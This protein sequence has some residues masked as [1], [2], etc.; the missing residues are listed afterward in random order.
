MLKLLELV[1]K[2][3]NLRYDGKDYFQVGGAAIRTGIAPSVANLWVILRTNMYI[4]SSSKLVY[5]SDSWMMCSE[6]GGMVKGLVGFKNNLNSV[7]ENLKFTLEYS[8]EN[9][10]FLDTMVHLQ[11]GM[12]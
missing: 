9:V 3:N 5:G 10:N 2:V 1:Q 6:F 8:E 7:D 12:V 4:H 11:N